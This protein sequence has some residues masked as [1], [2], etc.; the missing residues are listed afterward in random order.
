MPEHADGAAIYEKFVKPASVDLLKLGAHYAMSSLFESYPDNT[1][2]Y[3][4]SVD[5]KD[6]RLK[7]SGKMRL[8]F[9]KARFTSEITQDS[10]MLMFGVLHF[11][12][13]N[14]HGGVALYRSEEAYRDLSKATRDAFNRSDLAATIHLPGPGIRRPHL[15]A[16]ESIP[17]RTAE[18]VDGGA[19]IHG[20]T[21]FLR[22]ARDL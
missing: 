15:F 17:R 3:A 18:G 21:F 7:R 6:Y 1:R 19:G 11:G 8:A 20:G 16:Q 5:N 12:D 14:L 9:G 2:I 13:H 10:E 22:R 4:Y